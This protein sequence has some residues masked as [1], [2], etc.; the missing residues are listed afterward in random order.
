MVRQR[1]A[2]Y[3]TYVREKFEAAV[4]EDHPA[5]DI[6]LSFS[7]GLFVA[8]LPNFGL[9][10][11]LFGLLARYVDRVSSLALLAVLVVMNP[12][13]KW[14]IYVAGLWVGSRLLGPVP[15]LSMSEFSVS[16]LSVSMGPELFVRL[17]VGTTCIAALAA[18]VSYIGALR[19]IREFRQRE[20]ELAEQ[21]PEVFTE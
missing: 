10:L 15:G 8:A 21:L 7:G 12:P 20:I 5:T 4:S 18:L 19:F 16:Q 9:A 2:A 13:V 14:A 11:V 6:A 1:L 17:F 3:K